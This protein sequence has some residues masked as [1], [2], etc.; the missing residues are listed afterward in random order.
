[1][2]T[3][4][5]IRFSNDD[6]YLFKNKD[7]S[8]PEY[9]DRINQSD[10]FWGVEG[11]ET[12]CADPQEEDVY[13]G[14]SIGANKYGLLAAD[15]HVRITT[16]HASNYDILVETVLKQG[17]D[18]ETAISALHD[19]ITAHPSWWGNLILSDATGNAAIE[20]RDSRMKVE[21]NLSRVLRTNHQHLHG[22]DDGLENNDSNSYGRFDWGTRRINGVQNVGDIKTMLASHDAVPSKGKQTGIC[23]H[24]YSQTVC[25]Y[26][27]HCKRGKVILH[28]VRGQPCL[29]GPYS[30]QE[31]FKASR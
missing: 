6:Y 21:R 16:P 14:L 31:L 19:R 28:S 11:L 25:S 9:T 15:S 20:V 12:F 2:C 10:L 26:L 30:K 23:N 13:S 24:T 29:A 22:A 3:I 18:I 4:G 1:M 8:R 7:F 17:R 5:A 27:L